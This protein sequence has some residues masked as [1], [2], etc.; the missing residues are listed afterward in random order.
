[1]SKSRFLRPALLPF[2]HGTRTSS[3]SSAYSLKSGKN[4]GGCAWVGAEGTW[5]GFVIPS[6]FCCKSKMSLKRCL[7]NGGNNYCEA[8]L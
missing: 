1:M 3:W 2:I 6:Q 4:W 5:K 8:L 7:K